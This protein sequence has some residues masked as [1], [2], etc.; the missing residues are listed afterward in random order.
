M[1][2]LPATAANIDAIAAA[3][4]ATTV[5][6]AMMEATAEKVGM[7]SGNGTGAGG[8]LGV[9]NWFSVCMCVYVLLW[10]FKDSYQLSKNMGWGANK[11][12]DIFVSS[13]SSGPE[14][15]TMNI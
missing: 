8:S 7:G 1:A 4:P 13:Y 11:M 10:V 14:E 6:A 15:D 5:E 3:E 12:K 9:E 2:A